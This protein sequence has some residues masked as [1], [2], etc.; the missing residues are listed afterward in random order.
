MRI[1]EIESHGEQDFYAGV[2]ATLAEILGIDISLQGIE[3]GTGRSSSKFRKTTYKCVSGTDTFLIQLNQTW[4]FDQSAGKPNTN[5]D[6]CDVDGFGN[7]AIDFG[8]MAI[9]NDPKSYAEDLASGG[10]IAHKIDAL[11]N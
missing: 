2:G 5:V 9:F 10:E 4:G 7:G 1:D 8:R 3:T 6:V 11:L